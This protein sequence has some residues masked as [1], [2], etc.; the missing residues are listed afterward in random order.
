MKNVKYILCLVTSI[1]SINCLAVGQGGWSMGVNLGF[2]NADQDDMNKVINAAAATTGASE[3]GNAWEL[4]AHISYRMSGSSLALS[5][6]PSYFLYDDEEGT[7]AT[8]SLSGFSLFPMLKWYM[9]EDQTIKFYSQFGI[10][11]GQINGEI[12]KGADFVEFSGGNFGYMAGLG[13]E[14][15]FA[16]GSSCINVEGNIRFLAVERFE[17]DSGSNTSFDGITQSQSGREVELNNKDLAASMSGVLAMI[18]YTL[19]F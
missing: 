17:A 5:F 10:G 3:F 4:N 16:G 13:A 19:Y 2:I 8:Y 14:F 6:R 1:F 11:Y 15:C 9:L 12:D 18:G 7:G